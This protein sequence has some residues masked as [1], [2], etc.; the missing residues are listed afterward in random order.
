LALAPEILIAAERR[1]KAIKKGGKTFEFK[2]NT[3]RD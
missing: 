2:L 1:R 3:F